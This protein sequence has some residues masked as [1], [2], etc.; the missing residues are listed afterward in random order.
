MG[1]TESSS[2]KCCLQSA[3]FPEPRTLALLLLLSAV[4]TVAVLKRP[5]RESNAPE[6]QSPLTFRIPASGLLPLWIAAP[7]SFVATFGMASVPW[8][9]PPLGARWL[10]VCAGLALLLPWAFHWPRCVA[11]VWARLFEPRAPGES[12]PDP[13]REVPPARAAVWTARARALLLRAMFPTMVYLAIVLWPVCPLL[14]R[15]EDAATR[16]ALSAGA[17]LL[18]ILYSTKRTYRPSA[19]QCH[20]RGHER[21]HHR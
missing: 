11:R 2:S 7:M 18:F 9:Q 16:I 20:R 21:L 5:V 4:A 8:P 19:P 1:R 13:G 12:A 10:A 14:E 17:C 3:T 15:H 6:G